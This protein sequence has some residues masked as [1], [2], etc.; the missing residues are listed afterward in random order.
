MIIACRR[1][2]VNRCLERAG[3]RNEEGGQDRPSPTS[4]ELRL[5]LPLVLKV[6]EE[7]EPGLTLTPTPEITPVPP[8]EVDLEDDPPIEDEPLLPPP[9]IDQQTGPPLEEETLPE[10][11]RALPAL[12]ITSEA[13]GEVDPADEPDVLRARYV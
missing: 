1:S 7:A 4:G 6:S 9:E 5:Y 13:W 11:A 12:L 8:P 2:F 10:R 3:S